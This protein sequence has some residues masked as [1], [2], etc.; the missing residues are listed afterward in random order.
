M[1]IPI[2]RLFRSLA[3]SCDPSIGWQ[4]E[5]WWLVVL[6]CPHHHRTNHWW[7]LLAPEGKCKCIVEE[8][9]GMSFFLDN[10]LP[11]ALTSFRCPL[12]GNPHQQRPAARRPRQRVPPTCPSLCHCTGF[13]PAVI[14]NWL[15][16]YRTMRLHF[17]FK[18]FAAMYV[19]RVVHQSNHLSEWSLY[20]FILA[21]IEIF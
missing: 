18:Q 20:S 2:H 7:F 13:V 19:K 11:L 14:Q 8:N 10:N 4:F 15:T 3:S 9:R 5:L 6:F 21:F 16:D 17:V 12:G 1:F